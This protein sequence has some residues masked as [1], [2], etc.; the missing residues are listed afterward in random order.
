MKV[1]L[2]KTVQVSDEQRKQMGAVIDNNPKLRAATRDEIKTYIWD[3]GSRWDEALV[4][5]F[6][7]LT[8][9]PEEESEES[10]E[11]LEDLI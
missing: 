10:E 1:N 8:G 7:E 5:D 2:Y 3:S 9:A 11:D 4:E 6:A